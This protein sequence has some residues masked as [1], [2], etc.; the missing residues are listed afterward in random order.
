[1]KTSDITSF[2][3]RFIGFILDKATD[4]LLRVNTRNVGLSSE[5]RRLQRSNVYLE[6]E[7]DT[8]ARKKCAII[9]QT[10][11]IDAR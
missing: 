11:R 7:P 6:V 9:G 4:I 2:V 5:R 1:M 10:R 8:H 3:L